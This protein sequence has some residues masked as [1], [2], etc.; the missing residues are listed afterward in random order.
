MLQ[1]TQ[2]RT[3]LPYYN[4][5][6]RRFPEVRS[7]AAAEEEEVLTLWAGLGY[8]G[9]ARNLR[10][11]AQKIVRDFNGRLPETP[12]ALLQLPG[13]GR[14]TAG[15]IRSI[16]FNDPQP[17]VDGNVK[18]ALSRL[19]GARRALTESQ[20]WDLAAAMVSRTHPGDFNQALMDLG[21]TVCTFRQPACE[22]CPVR[23]F[24]EA[25]N[26]GIQD[27]IPAPRAVR[28]ME[29]VDIALLVI[30]RSD[31]ILVA[32]NNFA[33]FVPGRH[34]LPGRIVESSHSTMAAARK[35]MRA[36]F[37]SEFPICDRARIRHSISFRRIC[38]HVFRADATTDCRCNEDCAWIPRSQI[39]RF[40]TSAFYLK[41]LRS[42]NS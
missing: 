37:G 1:Q 35:L 19:Y 30:R 12:E 18:R 25:W 4:R 20:F 13:I 5:F 40:F 17:V 29:K 34:A 36:I 15:A 11:A 33:S 10:L 41:A 2:V 26:Q 9:R 42:V 27:C 22:R 31:E 24:C 28:A 7:L 16:A 8:Y 23:Q 3:V 14:Y 39:D 6:L 38:A 32:S 21:A